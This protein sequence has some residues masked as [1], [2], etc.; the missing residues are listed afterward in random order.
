VIAQSNL[1]K[2]FK[3]CRIPHYTNYTSK[4]KYRE[5]VLEI[6]DK[7]KAEQ[8]SGGNPRHPLTLGKKDNTCLNSNE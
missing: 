4:E 5:Q 1:G 7:Q 6:L 3:I 8:G 2:E